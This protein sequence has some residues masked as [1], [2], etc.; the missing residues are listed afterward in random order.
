MVSLSCATH[1]LTCTSQIA[2]DSRRHARSHTAKQ[3]RTSK[4]RKNRQ[5]SLETVRKRLECCPAMRLLNRPLWA[6][7]L[8]VACCPGSANTRSTR[9]QSLTLVRCF[10]PRNRCRGKQFDFCAQCG[11]WCT[12]RLTCALA[13][14]NFALSG[15]QTLRESATS[16]ARS[17]LSRCLHGYGAS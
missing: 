7:P 1:S 10:W 17:Q 4:R 14:R 6:C 3:A 5:T 15:R 13:L 8:V 16:R 2:M 9:F 12:D 11:R